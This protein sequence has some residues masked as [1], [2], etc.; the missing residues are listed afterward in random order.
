MKDGWKS[1]FKNKQKGQ[2]SLKHEKLHMQNLPLLQ[3]PTDK[4]H[5]AKM[6]VRQWIL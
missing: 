5:L 2:K 1:E 3:Y 4:F 6:L